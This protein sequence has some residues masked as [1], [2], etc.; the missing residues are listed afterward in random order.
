[1]TFKNSFY[2]GLLLLFIISCNN[3]EKAQKSKTTGNL[4]I[5]KANPQPGD[6]LDL[7]YKAEDPNFT[8]DD[9]SALFYVLV[10]DNIYAEDLSMKDNEDA[11]EATVRIPDSATAIAFNFKNDDNYDTNNN[12]GYVFELYENGKT[13]PGA[14]AAKSN[15]HLQMDGRMEI[16]DPQ[17]DSI[18]HWLKTDIEE[19][20]DIE[21]D[22]QETYAQTLLRNDRTK[23]EEYIKERLA[24]IEEKEERSEEDY[25]ILIYIYEQLQEEEKKDSVQKLGVAQYPKGELAQ[26]S[27]RS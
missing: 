14:L 24:A 2:Y 16:E 22:W 17:T 3:P 12:L 25:N 7:R 10:D 27:F 15:F 9:F 6:D 4:E 13:I 5:S 26:K 19:H 18:V 11:K 20:P 8:N 1:M 23:G 21:E